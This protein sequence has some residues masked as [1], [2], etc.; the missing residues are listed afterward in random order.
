MINSSD[1]IQ[2]IKKNLK[3]LLQKNFNSGPVILLTHHRIWDDTLIS[4]K[5]MQH[6]KS[7][8][9]YGGTKNNDI[10]CY[11]NLVV[12]FDNESRIKKTLNRKWKL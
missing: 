6:D 11:K 1:S 2:N 5:P 12:L 7:Y 3:D 4:A 9:F 8:Y 10:E